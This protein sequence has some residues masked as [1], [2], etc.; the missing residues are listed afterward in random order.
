M[1]LCQKNLKG[2]TLVELSV[3]IVIIGLII[4]GVTAGRSI[5]TTAKLN[6]QAQELQKYDFAFNAF[7]LKY[8]AV[9]GDMKNASA[10]WPDATD[11]DGNG[12]LNSGSVVGDPTDTSLELFTLFQH[13]SLA[14]L[15][16][17]SYDNTYTLGVGYP[18]LK[19][20]SSK[21][22]IGAGHL[23]L[24]FYYGWMVT[25]EQNTAQHKAILALIVSRPYANDTGYAGYDGISI[26]SPLQ[27]YYIDTKIDD[28]VP[29]KGK[30]N[31]YQ[32]QSTFS[33]LCIT[34]YNG[35]YVNTNN[36]T[37][38]AQYILK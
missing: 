28:G 20:D 2:F 29:M 25:E 19:I 18:A 16:S 7:A 8:N 17:G 13:L 9:A 14:K 6:A 34:D 32:N 33:E 24:P 27:A 31:A 22:M 37:C 36:V 35:V 1:E 38:M 11:G 26:M 12:Y 30:F 3:V 10:Y 23:G 15:I 4:A 21:G 5:I